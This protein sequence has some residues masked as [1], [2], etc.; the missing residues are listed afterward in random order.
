M[1]GEKPAMLRSTNSSYLKA[2]PE[3]AQAFEAI[4]D[5]SPEMVDF[6]DL[7]TD[8]LAEELV[9]EYSDNLH[10]TKECN[11]ENR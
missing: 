9:K 4:D 5:L 3:N 11:E 1:A 6:I 7:L 2:L 10:L 8:I